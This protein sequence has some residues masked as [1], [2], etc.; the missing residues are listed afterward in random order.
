MAVKKKVRRTR[1][2]PAGGGRKSRP[3]AKARPRTA[4]RTTQFA[5]VAEQMD[6]LGKGTVEI[7]P[8][9][10][11]R[12]RLE[13]SRKTGCPLSVKAGF[14]PSAPDLHLGHTVIIRKL[15]HFQQLGHQVYF[16]IGDF[17][18]R[19]GDP[20]GQS[21]TRPQLTEKQVRANAR[22][23]REQIGA[24]LDPRR[25]KVVFNNRW[26]G[27]MSAADFLRLAGTYTVARMLEREDFSKRLGS[28]QPIGMHE[29]FYPLAQAYDSVEIKAD[30]ELGGTDQKFNLL[31]GREIMRAWDL[32]PQV[33]MT[34]PLLEGLDGVEKMSKS[35]GNYIALR[36]EPREMYGKVMSISDEL[37]LRYYELCTD[38]TPSQI[39]TLRR[40]VDDGSLHPRDA[41]ADLARRIVSDFH[42]P[43]AARKAEAH[44]EQVHRERQ[45]P[46]TIE[47]VRLPASDAP[48]TLPRALVACGLAASVSEARRLIEQGGVSVDGNRN[49]S[50]TAA[51]QAGGHVLQVG[52]RRFRRLVLS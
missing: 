4:R 19:I 11:L 12:A 35:L 30:V 18:G 1:G 33:V 40:D 45:T 47:E 43:A 25:T 23:Y 41:K 39:A 22:T 42:G 44:F 51:L 24:L 32:E 14:D 8:E 21:K 31:V 15:R 52:K 20:S 48:L 38:L 26:L 6:Y 3:A 2:R 50:V 49:S 29:L 37:M 27:R 13:R 16:L 28:N 5:P 46:D 17:T 7:I 34:L 9:E 10:D 36:D